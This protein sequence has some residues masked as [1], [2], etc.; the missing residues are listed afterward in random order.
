M[1]YFLVQH[2]FGSVM[3]VTMVL[4]RQL[5]DHDRKLDH[6]GSLDRCGARLAVRLTPS[7][8][9][10]SGSW[11][12]SRSLHSCDGGAVLS[13]RTLPCRPLTLTR[14]MLS[15]RDP[16]FTMPQGCL[17]TPQPIMAVLGHVSVYNQAESDT[18]ERVHNQSGLV[19]LESPV[20]EITL[21][22]CRYSLSVTVH[23]PP[24]SQ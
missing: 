19:G 15:S 10:T 7:P 17:T 14:R 18:P 13:K 20:L 22:V 16:P 6:L 9:T 12:I 3:M 1:V 8:Y 2:L 24:S 4:A 23:P 21:P 5:V 11:S